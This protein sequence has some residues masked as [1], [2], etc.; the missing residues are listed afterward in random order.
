MF[1]TKVVEKI[2]TH[3]LFSITFFFSK[4]AQFTRQCGKNMVQPDR[5]QMTIWR[6]RIA[7][8]IPK[9]TDTHS[10]YV[11]LILFPLQQWLHESTSILRYRYIDCLFIL[12]NG[13]GLKRVSTQRGHLQL[14]NVSKIDNKGYRVVCVGVVYVCRSVLEKQSGDSSITLHLFMQLMLVY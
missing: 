2:K 6:T 12:N 14:K 8:S 3:I 11:T 9:A 7:C 10:E 13:R 5:P 4:I 1:Q